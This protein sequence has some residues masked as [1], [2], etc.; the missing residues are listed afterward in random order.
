MTLCYRTQTS[1]QGEWN[2]ICDSGQTGAD[3]GCTVEQ[4]HTSSIPGL[5]PWTPSGTYV[6]MYPRRVLIEPLQLISQRS[7]NAGYFPSQWKKANV[8][9]IFKKK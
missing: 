8:I 2:I 4:L 3:P 1:V 7:V 5:Y 9:P 6:H